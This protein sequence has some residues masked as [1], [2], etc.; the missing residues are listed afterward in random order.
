MIADS[1]RECRPGVLWCLF[2][3][4]RE[5]VIPTQLVNP[6]TVITD[7]ADGAAL[8][9]R[10]IGNAHRRVGNGLNR[11]DDF[12]QRSISVLSLIGSG[13]GVLDLGAHAFHRLPC[14][15]LQAGDQG[16]DL[17]R[18]AGGALRQ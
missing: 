16:L 14:R 18:G 12:I 17:G 10:D 9:G 5:Q 4:L 2:W 15:G 8:L 13:F 1:R 6:L 3:R 11:P 7:L